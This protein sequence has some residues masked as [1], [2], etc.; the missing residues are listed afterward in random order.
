MEVFKSIEDKIRKDFD[1]TAIVKFNNKNYLFPYNYIK[2]NILADSS[3]NKYYK[4]IIKSQSSII[5]D[6]KIFEMIEQ[7]NNK[8]AFELLR[9][10]REKEKAK[11]QESLFKTKK[12]K[13][14]E[15]EEEYEHFNINNFME[16]LNKTKNIEEAGTN[17]IYTLMKAMKNKHNKNNQKKIVPYMDMLLKKKKNNFINNK[18]D[19]YT[20]QQNSKLEKNEKI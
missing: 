13:E 15:Q 5:L 19:S 10:E 9:S 7:M 8:K 2:N 12:E 11:I 17:I 14:N 3:L 6:T 4:Y 16:K 18:S 20:S 1:K